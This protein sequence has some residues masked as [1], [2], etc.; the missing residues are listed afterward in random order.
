MSQEQHPSHPPHLGPSTTV[1]VVVTVPGLV[2]ALNVLA[3]ERISMEDREA[4]YDIEQ[5]IAATAKRM[6]ALDAQT[7]K[8]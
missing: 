5:R 2:E 1:N 3:G 7:G 8:R 4:L 6:R